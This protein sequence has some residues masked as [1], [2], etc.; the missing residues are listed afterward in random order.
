M[1]KLLFISVL[2]VAVGSMGCYGGM[3]NVGEIGVYYKPPYSRPVPHSSPQPI[4]THEAFYRTHPKEYPFW[5][6]ASVYLPEALIHIIIRCMQYGVDGE[7]HIKL[8]MET[9]H[10]PYVK[11]HQINIPCC[12]FY[13]QI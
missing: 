4:S 11:F 10:L 9:L 8:A 1:N 6:Q 5:L 13:C 12:L 3:R 7:C 2:C